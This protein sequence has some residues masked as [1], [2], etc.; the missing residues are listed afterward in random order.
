[1]AHEFDE[2]T[3][4]QLQ[5]SVGYAIEHVPHYSVL[6][7]FGGSGWIE[8]LDQK[9]FS[10][11]PLTT[12]GDL[13][14]YPM[15]AMSAVP[16]SELVRVLATS[17]TT[18]PAVLSGETANDATA[19]AE[20]IASAIRQIGLAEGSLVAVLH[21]TDRLADAQAL[22]RG[23]V[24]AGCVAFPLSGDL[25]PQ[26]LDQIVYG[27][28][29]CICATPSQMIALHDAMGRAGFD[30]R[31][32][33]LEFALLGG[34]PMSDALL[35][36]IE[37]VFDIAVADIYGLAE[38]GGPGVAMGQGPLTV[39]PHRFLAEIV[40]PDTGQSLVSGEPG[41]L[42][43]TSLATEA[44]PVLRFRTRDIAMRQPDGPNGEQRISRIQG[45]LD[46]IVELRGERIL[47]TRIEAEILAIDGLTP[48]YRIVRL[49]D[50]DL[51]RARVEVE[52]L[53][54]VEPLTERLHGQCSD[55]FTVQL[56]EP[57]SL[58]RS[59]GRMI[60]CVDVRGC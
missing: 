12:K 8:Q 23:V 52:G 38:L 59:T 7:N 10:S 18:G 30:P 44:F 46:D 40:D 37:R 15:L 50:G 60:R 1:M 57:G 32:T 28:V 5:W 16:Q 51:D 20:T 26:H 53:A 49:R 3:R 14:A 6:A 17:G 19:S 41:E 24:R 55:A 25:R 29:Q 39:T 43:L 54:G 48:H 42:V 22:Q 13:R 36:W 4:R 45:R 21:G 27:A 35:Q 2:Q 31:D 58:P 11:L 9:V 56:V 47:P 33:A 34:E